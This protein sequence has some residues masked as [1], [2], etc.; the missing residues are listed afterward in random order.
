MKK[1]G[2]HFKDWV[3][4][5]TVTVVIFALLISSIV[6]F[7]T[8]HHWLLWGPA[9]AIIGF[10]IFVA[11]LSLTME[12]MDRRKI[13]INKNAIDSEAKVLSCIK[14]EP[15]KIG[16]LFISTKY[17]CIVLLKNDTISSAGTKKHPFKNGQKVTVRYL[18][19]DSEKC[20]IID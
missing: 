4:A 15:S 18:P 11:T 5:L 20:I 9:I 16:K 8:E 14:I 17:R 3:G 12:R 13:R 6:G 19:E 10:I 1:Q 7:L 2:L